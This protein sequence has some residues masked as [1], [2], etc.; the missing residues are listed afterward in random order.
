LDAKHIAASGEY[1]IFQRNL[2]IQARIK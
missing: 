1:W 2:Y